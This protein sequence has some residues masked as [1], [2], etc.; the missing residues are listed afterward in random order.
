MGNG[1][2]Q[3]GK[4]AP[5]NQKHEAPTKGDVEMKKIPDDAVPGGNCKSC[6]NPLRPADKTE[7]KDAIDTKHM[8]GIKPQTGYSDAEKVH[9][10][11]FKGEASEGDL[12]GPTNFISKKLK[13]SVEF[14]IDVDSMKSLLESQGESEE[15]VNESLE[16]FTATVNSILES[17]IEKIAF[18]AAAIVENTIEVE[19][20]ELEENISDYLDAAIIEWAEDNRLAIENDSV[21]N[22]S[23]SFVSDLYNLMESYNIELSE[24]KV[25]LYEK[26]VEAGQLVLDNY[27]SLKEEHDELIHQ[28]QES[29]KNEVI[30]SYISES[31][32]SHSQANKLASIMEGIEYKDDDD[33]VKKLDLIA[34]SVAGKSSNYYDNFTLAEDELAGAQSLDEDSYEED[35]TLKTPMNDIE[36]MA[37]KLKF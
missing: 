7:G 30:E 28:I 8:N 32:L 36:E 37:T 5:K 25:D 24:D 9:E 16:I 23:E 4:F 33:F 26:A 3:L 13:E 22:I 6:G 11:I 1:I 35:T 10:K 21:A 31:R 14:D 2:E 18:E 12:T 29:A 34:E 20:N 19:V 27:N 15:F 17:Q